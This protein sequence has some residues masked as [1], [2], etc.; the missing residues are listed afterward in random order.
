MNKINSNYSFDFLK[1]K[2]I[3]FQ[4]LMELN[5]NPNAINPLE[6]VPDSFGPE[7]ANLLVKA[8]YISQSR[9]YYLRESDKYM[10]YLSKGGRPFKRID[11]HI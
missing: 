4:F 8:R 6:L 9:N 10:N 2:T 5:W 7:V 11:N 3:W 1:C